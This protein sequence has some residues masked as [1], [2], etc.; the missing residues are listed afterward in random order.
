MRGRSDQRRQLHRSLHPITVDSPWHRVGIDLVGPI[1]R[2]DTGNAYIITCTDYFTKWPEAAAI[3]DKC[4][5]TVANFLFGLITRHGCPVII[6]SDQGRELI[7]QANSH[8]FDLTGI[9]HRISAAYH[10][11]TNGLEERFNQTLV[12]MLK[13]LTEDKPN[14]WDQYIDPALF[15]YR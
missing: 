14:S 8:L 2:T 12:N 6:Q 3:P 1:D 15:A 7:N 5:T 4:A 10:P 9:D 11:Q 13:K